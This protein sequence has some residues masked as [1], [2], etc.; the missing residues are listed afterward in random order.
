MGHTF[1]YIDDVEVVRRTFDGIE[2]KEGDTDIDEQQDGPA[3]VVDGIFTLVPRKEIEENASI[4]GAVITDNIVWDVSVEVLVPG[5]RYYSDMSG[6]PDTFDEH[7]LGTGL[8]L[9]DAMLKVWQAM[10]ESNIEGVLE[11]L[12][13]EDMAKEEEAH[14]EDAYPACMEEN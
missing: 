2:V 7:E 5:T 1:K 11:T 10:T 6:D 8:S 14:P 12:S 3:I 4:C 13:Y 9:R